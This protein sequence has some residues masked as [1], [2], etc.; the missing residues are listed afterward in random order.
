MF[1]TKTQK[2]LRNLIDCKY[3]V[4]FV[5]LW[6]ILII[7]IRTLPKILMSLRNPKNPDI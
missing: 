1:P 2:A 7:Q 4:N 6:E 3:F 5:A